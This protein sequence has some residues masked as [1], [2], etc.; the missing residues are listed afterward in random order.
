MFIISLNY[1]VPLEEVD[2]HMGAHIEHLQ[3]YYDQHIFIVWGRKEPRTGGIIF[4]LAGSKEEVEKIIS[5]D[6]FYQ[7]ELAEFT[8][9]EFLPSQY[10]P[11]LKSLLG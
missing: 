6:P 2:E 4:A 1:I 9:T 8:I 5:E 10:R 11:E 7:H 3:K